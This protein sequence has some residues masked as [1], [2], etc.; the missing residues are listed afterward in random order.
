ML[1]LNGILPIETVHELVNYTDLRLKDS[2]KYTCAEALGLYEQKLLPEEAIIELCEKALGVD[3]YIPVNSYVPPD[4]L[5]HFH[6]SDVV[7]V[8]YSPLRGLV[9]CVA[10]PELGTQYLPLPN[11]CKVD[12][13][14]TPIY[15]YFSEYMKHYGP[16]YDLAEVP[17]KVLWDAIVREAISLGAADITLSSV[18]RA[19][20]AYFNVRK[21]KVYS[22]RILSTGNLEDI[23]KL[24]CFED[25]YDFNSNAPKYVG[26]DLNEFFR[27][28]VVVNKKY[29]GYAI[30][31][32]ILP[33]EAFNRPLE[34]CNLTPEVIEFIRYTMMNKELGLR[35]IVGSTMS[36][37]NTTALAMLKE[38]TEDDMSKVVSI[39]MPV[40]QELVGIEQINCLN[41]EEYELNI[42]S[43]LRQ[44]PDF[45]YLTETGDTNAMSI[46]R[47][48]NTGKR[49]LS[50][51]HANSCAD[52]IGRLVDI[53]GLGTDRIIQALHSVV[54]Q[55]L[56][57]EEDSDSVRPKDRYMYFSQERKNILYGLSHGEIIQ[58]I[59]EWEGGDVW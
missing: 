38:L 37:K 28:R 48:T 45:I 9:T 46:M 27:G 59:N 13:L 15:N 31:I 54:Y 12:V 6:N 42:N 20:R 29:K 57:R 7:P 35:L 32:R 25:P 22:N 3:L 36:G 56:V 21:R 23:I 55:E 52:V 47:V 1:N 49:V 4:I 11:G 30:T 16:H 14:Y 26:C 41:E 18:G 34:D 5:E 17:A 51:L 39:E 44:N 43:L 19:S 53:T 33:N 50:T 58:K 40:E 24:L 10:M 2:N 8:S